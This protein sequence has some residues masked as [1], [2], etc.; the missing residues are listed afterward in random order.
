[1]FPEWNTKL[2]VFRRTIALLV[3]SC[4]NKQFL[5]FCPQCYKTNNRVRTSLK[6][7]EKSL[8]FRKQNPD[9]KK[10]WKNC[11]LRN[12]LKSPGNCRETFLQIAFCDLVTFLEEILFKNNLESCLFYFF[13][14]CNPRIIV[15]KITQSNAL[16]RR[17]DILTMERD[18]KIVTK[19]VTLV[20]PKF[21]FGRTERLQDTSCLG[22]IVFEHH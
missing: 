14:S 10:S 21:E 2:P 15:V 22:F 18:Q 7:L 19:I 17:A 16:R 9:L 11:I 1:M 4:I 8:N 3:H 6:I 12:V 13:E 5:L 20:L